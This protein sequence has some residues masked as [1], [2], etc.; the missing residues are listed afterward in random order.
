MKYLIQF[1]R[2][3]VSIQTP[4]VITAALHHVYREVLLVSVQIKDNP[5][6]YKVPYIDIQKVT[7]EIGLY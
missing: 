1:Q 7:S 5:L 2:G 6:F 3:R 4:S